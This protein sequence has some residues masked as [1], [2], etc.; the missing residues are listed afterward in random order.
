MPELAQKLANYFSCRVASSPSDAIEDP[1]VMAV[2]VCTITDTH[3]DFIL[4]AN[5]ASKV[6]FCEK[7]V[8]GTLQ[9]ALERKEQPDSFR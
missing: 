6:V 2:Y 4:Q 5:A 3:V 9:K 1:S 7:P 8:A